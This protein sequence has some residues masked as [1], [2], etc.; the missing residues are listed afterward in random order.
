MALQKIVLVDDDGTARISEY[1]LE[2][3]LCNEGSSKSVSGDARWKAPEVVQT[4]DEKN[5]VVSVDGGKRADVYS[6]AMIIFEVG[7]GSLNRS[8]SRCLTQPQTLTGIT[9]FQNESD[10]EVA[11]RVKT[12]LR[13]EWLSNDPSHG[14]VDALRSRVEACWDHDPE[15]RPTAL[16]MFQFMEALRKER[17]EERAEDSQELPEQ[18]IDDDTWDRVDDAP[19]L[20]AF[21]HLGG[22]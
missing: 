1:G 13:P 16:E 8:A 20:G 7:P 21:D 4:D 2:P 17:A 9:P 14:L 5:Q 22:R 18:A 3:L 12:G 10:E 6:F 11:N 15:K 19:E